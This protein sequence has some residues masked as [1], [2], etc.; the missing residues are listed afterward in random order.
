[1]KT[2]TDECPDV[3]SETKPLLKCCFC[4]SVESPTR[5]LRRLHIHDHEKGIRD[6]AIAVGCSMCT[7]YVNGRPLLTLYGGYMLLQRMKELV[8]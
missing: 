1:M 4:N 6:V 2:S 7:E 3:K 5:N 8:K